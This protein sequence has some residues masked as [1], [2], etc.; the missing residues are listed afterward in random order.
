MKKTKHFAFILLTFVL[1]FSLAACGGSSGSK[2]SAG[3]TTD[4]GSSEA[5]PAKTPVTLTLLSHFVGDNE[6]QIKPYIDQWNKE[7]PDIQIQ[8]SGVE[9]DQLLP[10]IMAKQTSGQGADIMHIYSLW[11]G[12]LAKS[13]VLADAP[14]DVVQDVQSD[15]PGAAANGASV[16]GAIFGYPTEVETFALFYNKKLLKDAG[17][18]NPPASWD[19]LLNMA[20]KITKK[21]SSGKTTTE[22]FGLI[23]GWPAVVAQPFEGF[24]ETAGGSFMSDDQSKV[25]LDSDAAKKVMDFYSKIYGK[26][27]ISDIGFDAMKGFGTGN[28]G[29]TVNAGWWAGSLK[30]LMKDD[31]AN[32]GTAPLPSPDGSTKGS[33]AYTWAWAVNKHS[34]HQE[35]AWKFLKWFNTAT[36]KNDM[37]P[38]GNFLLDAFNVVST[39]TSDQQSQTIKDKL[40]NDDVLKTFI[41]AMSYAKSEPNPTAGAEMQN[42]IFKEI[43][44]VW[45]GQETS[46]AALKSMQEQIQ[47]K[48]G[49]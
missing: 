25:N 27:G 3:Q 39:R 7:N 24:M 15:Y 18:D 4:N 10:T 47:S 19:E 48:L 32:V 49:Q 21:D 11:A 42:I 12:Q 41:D 31:Y 37:T 33:I 17:F 45:T 38:E 5:T 28:V 9:F 16:N 36:V 14:P 8:L 26:G 6:T 46:D 22:G 13:S 23:K 44:N 40:A 43:N 34:K 2:D 20:K 1:V 30:T 35:E 29:M